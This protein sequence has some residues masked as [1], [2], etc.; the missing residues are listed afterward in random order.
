MARQIWRGRGRPLNSISYKDGRILEYLARIAVLHKVD[1]SEFFNCIVEAWNNDG[2]EC[3]QLVVKCR[4]RKK[5][6]ANFLFTNERKVVAQFPISIAIL[7]GKDQLESFTEAILA[8]ASSFKNFEGANSK[9]GD[10]KVGMK[11]ISLKAKVLEIPKSRIV[12]TRYGTTACVS[13]ALI[14]DETGSM[15]M[16]LW[17][18]QI[19]TVHEG[20]VIDVKNGKVAWF[21]GERQL[22][23]G[24]SGSL[25]VIECAHAL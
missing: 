3:K 16:S 17:N 20:D 10:L 5:N 11:K 8:R 6:S 13:N 15:K 7:R 12:Q 19:D 25:S 2:S 22:R 9:I 1:S 4:K 14:R 21:S 18:Q 24:R 23:L